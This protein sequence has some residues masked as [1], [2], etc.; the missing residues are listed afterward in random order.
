MRDFSSVW[1]SAAKVKFPE[2]GTCY[3]F[4]WNFE[5][6]CWNRWQD[7]VEHY[8]NM[9]DGSNV[10]NIFSKIYV[11][12][13]HT[14][15]LKYM[16][17]V[18][19]KR[20]KP[21][22]FIGGAGTGKTAVIKQFL[23]STDSAKVASKTIN[24][25]SFTDSAALQKNIESIVEKKSGRTFGSATNKTLICFIDDLNMPFVDKYTT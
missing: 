10:W 13:V 15:R 2:N 14:T 24:F 16:I 22:L 12:T 20:R 7:K 11:A 8:V 3:D 25:S 1:K 19:L 18:H 5:D 23:L 9:D 4:Y 6:A 21:F 17:Q